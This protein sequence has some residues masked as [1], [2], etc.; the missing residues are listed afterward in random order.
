MYLSK[1]KY[2]KGIQCK[3]ILWL[4]KNKS[5]VKQELDNSSVFDNGTEVG[6][7][8]QD[9]F[10]EHK[11]VEFNQDLSKMINDTNKYLQEE[12]IVL[13]EASLTYNNN[14]CSVDIL[15]KDKDKYEIYEVKSSTHVSDIYLD[16][17]SYQYYVLK[18]LG[19]NVV[20]ACIVYINSKYVR[21]GKLD[22]FQLF[23]IKDVTNIAK[24]KFNEV[25]KNIKEINEYMNNT[26][27][28]EKDISINCFSPY[29]CPF[30]EYCSRNI[31][32]PNVF[33]IASM[34]LEDKIKYYKEGIYSYKDLLNTNINEKY[35]QQIEFTL[36][37]KD[38]YIDKKSIKEFLKTLSYP[39]YFLDFETY[40]QSIPAFDDVN[41]YMQIPFQ[42]SLHYYEKEN[43]E[44]KHK[45]FLASSSIKDPRK[46]LALS[47]INDIPKDVCV[48]AYNMAFEKSVIKKLAEL[49]PEYK[50]HLLNIESNIKDLII[51]FR[52][53]SY[54]SK[55]M[56]GSFSI[57]YVLPAL[58][59]NDPSLDYHNLDLI[60]KGDEASS[61]FNN[62]DKL[63]DKEK[64]EVRNALLKYCELD[65]YAMVKIYNKLKEIA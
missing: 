9:L 34:H 45:E 19:L 41:P 2:C 43:G 24:E 14:F 46:D 4:E 22:I 32:K 23:N 56:N 8:A 5:E 20:K 44:L 65:T 57:K 29:P 13:C 58:F 21:K 7:L 40:Q 60:H 39:L 33:D 11:V 1:S 3:K 31:D 6:I 53:R 52:N 51:P 38:D 64:E 26:N 55:D 27:E 35:K 16:D 17:I 25:E 18:S 61:A 15:K 50:E 36:Y 54:Y 28:V 59:P 48:L 10:G 47:L 12:S 42:Y 63:S 30:Y 62:I 37:N 49:Y